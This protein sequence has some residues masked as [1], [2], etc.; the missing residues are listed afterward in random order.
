MKITVNGSRRIKGTIAVPLLAT[1]LL[2]MS[3]TQ[4]ELGANPNA[5]APAGE[6]IM[7]DLNWSVAGMNAGD[8]LTT[9]ALAAVTTTSDTRVIPDN[10][11]QGEAYDDNNPMIHNMWIIQFD[12]RTPSAKM[13]GAPRFLDSDDLPSLGTYPLTVSIPLIQ[14]ST[15]CYTL[16]V[17]N[18]REGNQYRWDLTPTST[19]ADV[20]GKV[21]TIRDDSGSYE[22]FSEG[23]TLLM[24]AVTN[25]KVEFGTSLEPV[26]TR[27]VAKVTLQL[28]VSNPAV[29]ITSV[30]LR[31]VSNRI[32]YGNAAIAFNGVG[33]TTVYPVDVALIDYP[34]ITSSSTDAALPTHLNP[35]ET[36]SWY[37]PRNQQGAAT[38]SLTAETKTYY[39]PA[40]ATYFEIVA[41]KKNGSDVIATS[42]FRVYPGANME[43]DFNLTANSH[44]TVALDVVDIGND[45]DSRV[46]TF[47]NID[48]TGSNTRGAS[49]N[50]F[51]L[52]PA[53]TSSGMTRTYRIPISQV[54]RFWGGTTEG[55]G[56]NPA[57]VII[58]SDSWKVEL[59]WSDLAGLFGS[60]GITLAD[61][62]L[63][64]GVGKGPD[65]YFTLNV[66]AGLPAGNFVL[67]IKRSGGDKILWSWHFW[68][69][70]YN[71][72]SFNFSK[73]S[74]NT[75]TYTVPGGQVER[76]APPASGTNVWTGTGVNAQ[77]VMMDR[78]LGAVE[79]FFN[80][81]P[82]NSNRGI[83]HYQFGRKDPFPTVS[84]TTVE[85]KVVGDASSAGSG[86]V[87]IAE[88]VSVPWS[89]YTISSGN[90]CNEVTSN[91][92]LWND[93]DAPAN[94]NSAKSIYDPCPLGWKVPV[95]NTWNDFSRSTTENG[96]INTQNYLRD[97]AWSNGRGIG[98]AAE[99]INGL[100][101]WPGSTAT[102][103][104]EGTIWYPAMG[105]HDFSTASLSSAGSSGY[106][107]SD[108]ANS[109]GNSRS[110]VFNNNVV[111]TN[112]NYNRAYGFAVRCV[113]E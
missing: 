103:P 70:D 14:R 53:P 60:S 6:E 42:V 50:S 16:F 13:I 100:R 12:D 37:I 81:Q 19:F 43:N 82:A 94:S 73:I 44:Y 15:E 67:G 99:I 9:A 7:V 68:V 27:N 33:S 38:Q 75:Y 66:P 84:V 77:K 41:I 101:Y 1:L 26:F 20:I 86:P 62:G 22:D 39:A 112:S 111:Y 35:T 40:N 104:V 69:T 107:W 59:I 25:S 2:A 54:N 110:F 78:N 51:I 63:G 29:E 105:F 28:K 18:I 45:T 97:L 91:T 64:V 47:K 30:R 61:N 113:A 102:A 93:P 87:T 11:N 32:A 10:M 46:Q 4:E 5:V 49:S 55:Y 71:P 56:N 31:K 21:K 92:Y 106:Y 76:Y 96:F 72:D 65:D 74:T 36:Y 108:T 109:D 34:A 88:T 83:L 79:N 3:C 23:N 57:N 89:F 85:N 17:A 58:D 24:S 52:N 8:E 80:K 95:N 98:S 90:W 48:Y